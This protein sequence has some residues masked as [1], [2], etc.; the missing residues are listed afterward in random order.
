MLPASARRMSPIRYAE[1][2]YKI[3][4]MINQQRNFYILVILMIFSI[5]GSS[6]DVPFVT[7]WKTDNKGESCDSCIEIPTEGDNYGYDVD[8]DNDGIY[9]EF[10][11]GNA[12]H[13][14]GTPGEYTVSIKGS[15]PR[16]YFN[17][18]NGAKES[19]KLIE[20]LQWGD[21]K[22]KTFRKAFKGCELLTIS[23]TD[24]PNLTE[25]TDLSEMFSGAK[26]LN[27]DFSSWD[28]SNIRNM[29]AMFN[30]AMNFN[31]DI[32]G[33]DV[34]N[35]TDMS[36]MFVR[37]KSFN[38]DISQWNV[39][40]V[41]NMEEMFKIA[42]SFNMPIGTWNV[43]NVTNMRS[44]FEEAR[45]FNQ[46]LNEWD[47][48]SIVVIWG[49]FRRASMFN[50]DLDNWNLSNVNSLIS[51][52]SFATNFNGDISTWD[53]S[54]VNDME[55]M[56]LNASS[57]DHSLG[58]WNLLSIGSTSL[59]D[60]LDNCGMK[61]LTYQSTLDGWASQS[62][63]PSDINLG[64]EGLFYCNEDSR[65]LLIQ[66]GWSFIG[67]QLTSDASLCIT[68]TKDEN[69]NTQIEI[70]PNPFLDV[71]VV[72]NEQFNYRKILLYSITGTLV[73]EV[74]LNAGTN[75]INVS[76]IP[77]GMYFLSIVGDGKYQTI[78]V[79]KK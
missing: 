38:N 79:L 45:A 17:D 72:K 24:A 37:A 73:S 58:Q 47:T 78:K 36:D 70:W 15:F 32:S 68:S 35:V 14:F 62:P 25:V 55:N 3:L 10:F 57:F 41:Q 50:Q 51:M 30:Y 19:Q 34:S 12:I 39:S 8:W 63:I 31:T 33:W 23:A 66:N 43:S 27:S 2:K 61:P 52:F 60:M 69:L 65:N 13:D 4:N 53:V 42:E 71:L 44:M 40:A 28:V 1:Y 54:N 64:C 16:I 11:T 75:E 7:K 49:M 29:S 5:Y 21:I 9:D 22:W 77:I 59:D 20:I 26:V 6:Q 74:V 46:P 48:G 56:L 18:W 67:D 76:N